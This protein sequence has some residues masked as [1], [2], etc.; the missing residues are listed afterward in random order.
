MG[1]WDGDTLVFHA[2]TWLVWAWQPR[3]WILTATNH[4]VHLDQGITM[5]EI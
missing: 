3:S 5:Q 1:V 2:A 4:Q